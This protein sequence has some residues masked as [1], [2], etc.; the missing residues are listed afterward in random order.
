MPVLLLYTV[1]SLICALPLIS[2]SPSFFMI[3][4]SKEL[5]EK[6]EVFRETKAKKQQKEVNFFISISKA[7][8]ALIRENTVS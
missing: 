5:K 7:P 3:A 8:G 6:F 1:F 4:N 2:A